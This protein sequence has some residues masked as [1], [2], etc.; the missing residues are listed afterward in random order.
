MTG[1]KLLPAA[2][3]M[4]LE[5]VIFED[6]VGDAIPIWSTVG[7][8]ARAAGNAFAMDAACLSCPSCRTRPYPQTGERVGANGREMLMIG[9]GF[10]RR[11]RL[12]GLYNFRPCCFEWRRIRD[13]HVARKN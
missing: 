3:R 8:S 5:G 6:V 1:G 13:Y 9:N 11:R 12:H 10:G 4:G 7:M 2:V